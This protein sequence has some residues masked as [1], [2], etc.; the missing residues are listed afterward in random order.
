[1]VFEEQAQTYVDLSVLPGGFITLPEK[2]F[3]VPYDDS[4][5]R[6]VP[7]L[8]FLISHP[9]L[10]LQGSE[11][12]KPIR[13]M[14]DLGLRSVMHRYTKMQQDHF[15]TRKPYALNLSIA[16]QLA[17]GGISATDDIA[18]VM[19]SHVHYDHHGD[20]EDFPNAKFILGSG[21]LKLLQEGLGGRGTHQ[22]FQADLLQVEQVL[23]LP[24]ADGG[25]AEFHLTLDNIVLKSRWTPLWTLPRTLDLFGDGSVYVVDSPGH[26]PGHIN[27]LCRVGPDRWVYLGGDACHDM[28]LL[29]GERRISTWED[30]HG[31]TLCIH[32]DK[33]AAEETLKMIH[34]LTQDRD[35]HIQVIMAHDWQWYS[36]HQG[37]TFPKTLIFQGQE[38]MVM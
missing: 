6:T 9:G 19:L 27:L 31:N 16:N 25:D 37:E 35:R 11:D 30:D 4:Q 38:T 18:F 29:T 34:R 1:M 2:S 15:R 14:F 32:L 8:A 13:M 17:S 10:P 23:E 20:P 26:L 36:K 5:K 33:A 3:V 12:R 7:S 28:R 24:H 22:H 21:S